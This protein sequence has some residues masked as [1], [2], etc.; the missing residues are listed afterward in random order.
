MVNWHYYFFHG[1]IYLTKGAVITRLTMQNHIWPAVGSW[2][3]RLPA[4]HKSILH[5]LDEMILVHQRQ[6]RLNTTQPHLSSLHLHTN[7]L[8]RAEIH[9]HI[10]YILTFCSISLQDLKAYYNHSIVLTMTHSTGRKRQTHKMKRITHH[11]RSVMFR[12]CNSSILY[13]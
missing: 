5:R 8:R 2:I 1:V 9:I 11:W 4:G 3:E 10:V 6:H 7:T 13:C 12:N